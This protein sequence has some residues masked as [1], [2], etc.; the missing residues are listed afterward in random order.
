[1]DWQ[2]E[3]SEKL[4][5]KNQILFSK[6]SVIL[7]ELSM[8]LP[9]Q[10][11]RA[12]ALW[13]FD[14]A[15]E[16]VS[17]LEEKFPGEQR[18]R[19]TLE[20]SRL[21]AAGEIK[22]PQAKREILNCHAAAKEISDPEGIALFHAVGQACSVVHTAGHAMG[23]PI[24]EMTA[25]VQRYGFEDCREHILNRNREYIEKLLYWSEN[26]DKAPCRWADF[27]IRKD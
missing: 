3:L 20:A 10:D 22:M 26:C 23:F 7:R 19:N 12:I 13:A 24:Y 11:H 18:P 2:E 5:R 1:M 25:I 16:A 17:R 15:E 14:L 21:W 4:K 6:N 27:M 9:E 8:L